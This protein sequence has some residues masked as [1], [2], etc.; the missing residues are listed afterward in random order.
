MQSQVSTDATDHSTHTG[1]AV[2][3]LSASGAV[4]PS[5]DFIRAVGGTGGIVLTLTGK[6][7][8][9]G[10]PATPVF[11]NTVF[12]AVRIDAGAG[13]VTF[14][15]SNGALFNGQSSWVM[16]NAFQWAI[17]IWDGVGWTCMGN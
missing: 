13:P 14:V 9:T 6:I 8:P 7:Y 2:L 10:N 17:F 1:A 3:T 15:D 4:P 5:T 12:H 16:N 11:V